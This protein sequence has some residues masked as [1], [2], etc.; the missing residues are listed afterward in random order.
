MENSSVINPQDRLSS[1]AYI[2]MKKC[3]DAPKEGHLDILKKEK[4]KGTE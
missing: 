1:S 2:A 4:R 3:G